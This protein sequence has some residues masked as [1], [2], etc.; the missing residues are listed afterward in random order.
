MGRKKIKIEPIE[1]ERNR[2]ATYL[3]R[4]TGLFKKAYELAVLTDS[5]VAVVVFGRNGK[6]SEYCSG[7]MDDFLLRYTEYNGTVEKRGPQH[8]ANERG[9]AQEEV[10]ERFVPSPPAS[11]RARS[12]STISSYSRARLDEGHHDADTQK[13]ADVPHAERHPQSMVYASDPHHGMSQDSAKPAALGKRRAPE[14]LMQPTNPHMSFEVQNQWPNMTVMGNNNRALPMSQSRASVDTAMPNV[15]QPD[16]LA[17]RRWSSTTEVDF[18]L[19]SSFAPKRMEAQHPQRLLSMP[20]IHGPCASPTSGHLPMTMDGNT[21]PF[22]LPMSQVNVN[23]LAPSTSPT[24][25]TTPP[26]PPHA[27]LMGMPNPMTSP[28]APNRFN[29]VLA[30]SLHGMHLPTQ[31]FAENMPGEG[32][33]LGQYGMKL[34]GDMMTKSPHDLQEDLKRIIPVHGPEI[35]LHN[36]PRN[37]PYYTRP[38]K[39]LPAH[40]VM[41]STGQNGPGNGDSIAMMVSPSQEGPLSPTAQ[42]P[43]AKSPSIAA[44]E[45]AHLPSKLTYFQDSTVV[46]WHDGEARDVYRSDNEGKT[47][48]LVKGPPPRSAYLLIQHPYDPQQAFILSDSTEHW[49]TKNRGASWQRFETQ[50]SPAVRTGSPMEFHAGDKHRDYVLF[51]GKKCGAW[52]P[53]RGSECEDMILY[54]DDGFASKTKLMAETVLRCIWA[55]SSPEIVVPEDAMLRIFCIGWGDSNVQGRSL[56][57]DD[58]SHLLQADAAHTTLHGTSIV[59]RGGAEK[60]RLYQSDDFFKT[61]RIVD[62]GVG[63]DARGFLGIGS[64]HRYLITA[65]HD[66][67]QGQGT[68]LSLYVS[69]DAKTWTKAKFPHG[70]ILHQN[71]YTILE[72][73][74]FHLLVDVLDASTDTGVLFMS[75]SSGTHFAQGLRGT[76][77]STSGV[78]DYE[79]LANVDGVAIT[80]IQTEAAVKRIKTRITTDEGS[81]WSYLQ[82]PSRDVNGRSIG[83]NT[84][85][86]EHCSLHLHALVQPHNIGRAFSSSAP[87][88]VMG[89]GSVGESLRPY[90]ECDTFMST[91]AGATWSMVASHPHIY[92]FGDQGGLVVLVPDVPGSSE[93]K[94]SFDYGQTWDSLNLEVGVTPFLLTTIPDGTALKFLLV[95][96]R[97]RGT[98]NDKHRHTAL[99]VDFAPLGMPKCSPKDFEKWYTQL[100][101]GKCLMGGKQWYQRRKK[102]SKC[103]VGE[104]F[105]DPVGHEDPCPCRKD[106]YEC[107]FGFAPDGSGVC[108]RVGPEEIPEGA[109][110]NKDDTYMAPSGY[111]KVPGNVCVVSAGE[112]ALDAPV[113]KQCAQAAPA[114][115]AVHHQ[116]F[117]FPAAIVEVV[118]LE[119]SPRILV[120]LQNGKVYQSSD[121]GG[122]WNMLAALQKETALA[123]VRHT[124]SKQRAYIITDAHTVYYSDDAG[125]NWHFFT[126]PSP[127][128]GLGLAWLDF[129][130]KHPNWLIWTGSEGCVPNSPG[131]GSNC[132]TQVFYSKDNGMNWHRFDKYVR[133]CAWLVDEHFGVPDATGILCESYAV[134]KGSQLGF[135]SG[136]NPLQLVLGHQFYT[137]PR[138]LFDNILGF[139]VF[140]RF[141]LVAEVVAN[142]LRMQVSL[143]AREFAEVRLPPQLQLDHRAYTVLDSVTEAVFLHV[144]TY[145]TMLAEWGDIIKSNSNGT[146][147]TLSL[148]RVNRNAYGYVDFEK[149]QGLDGVALAN[150]V[151]NPDEAS[152]SGLKQLQTRITHNDGGRWASISAPVLDSTGNGYPCTDVGCN[153]HLHGIL[154]RP[155]V[156]ITSSDSSVTGFMLGTGNVGRSLARYTDC[157][158]FL[159]RDGGFTWQEVHK[160]AHRWAFADHGSILLLVDDEGPTDRVLFTLNQGLSWKSYNLGERVRIWSIDAVPEEAT[161]KFVL[162]GHTGQAP[163]KPVA[164][165]LDFSSVLHRSCVFDKNNDEK[166]DY[167]RWSPSEQREET[168]LFGRQ[169]FYWRR[170]RDRICAVGNTL[171]QSSVERHECPCGSVDFECEFNHYRDPET[172]KCVLYPGAAA[173]PTNSA[174]QC[175]K[176]NPDYDGYWYERTNV[177][178]VRFSSCS[179]GIRLDQGTRHKCRGTRTGHGFFWWLFMLLL[180]GGAGTLVAKWWSQHG[181]ARY[182]TLSLEENDTYRD[183]REQVGLV[184]NFA[185]G[186][187]SLGWSTLLELA[188]N[189]PWLRERMARERHRYTN[190]HML[191]TD[192]DAEILQGYDS[193]DLP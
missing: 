4:K 33:A 187:I 109:C 57:F 190:Y 155:D 29:N 85:D 171:P 117:E 49:L 90:E 20:S 52:T 173:L 118:H 100:A 112:K 22:T 178:K 65:L 130:P 154:E 58:P 110:R 107:D 167:E 191:S 17:T 150:V 12:F 132:H 120:R 9:T 91:D 46:L 3:K 179:G 115:G 151:S 124:H 77:R 129:H 63:R 26:G 34:N 30:S 82:A 119:H 42:H 18:P 13:P 134:K 2:S 144:T 114:P 87:G 160:D 25:P 84:A 138:V 136:T 163:S 147:Y 1:G 113:Q 159:T 35:I 94:Y 95:G 41:N 83:C 74:K 140:E 189:V 97:A 158:T 96:S 174:E 31:Q 15:S 75:D 106:D 53:W 81:H 116:R 135:Q 172:Q 45:F 168:C 78:V 177:R 7:D 21:S 182:G 122:T 72:G 24:T 99:F 14:P 166:N 23:L 16:L 139:T 111:R 80:N 186:L 153:L 47:W 89:V 149:M 68:E 37:S 105:R 181:A 59:R 183:V 76:Y 98:G 152:V 184:R 39:G 55:K 19:L 108:H 126:V 146:Y 121:D 60:D 92:E 48:E 67:T 143:N 162:F 185:F 170:K 43:P 86:L 157:D 188:E 102:S 192:E 101:D 56:T 66:Y 28:H 133:K 71:A 127:A 104:K 123:I 176:Q 169:T 6:L 69:L 61:R 145:Q 93:M 10:F 44:S 137:K 50:Y 161:R 141:L 142:A 79:H 175:S 27:S 40:F 54:T 73:P 88:L 148:E 32:G 131:L 70:Q 36:T 165:F 11:K 164:I 125:K 5:D 51:I 193:D 64:S 62:M 38:D 128:N 156:Q 103:I 8:F 180:A